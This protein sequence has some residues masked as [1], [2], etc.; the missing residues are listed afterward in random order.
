MMMMMMMKE[1]CISELCCGSAWL[2]VVIVGQDLVQGSYVAFSELLCDS[3]VPADQGR[4]RKPS[5]DLHVGHSFLQI[6]F[7]PIYESAFLFGKFPGV[8]RLSFW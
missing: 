3:Q 8:A 5:L 2:T 6:Q 1:L 7:S 4:R